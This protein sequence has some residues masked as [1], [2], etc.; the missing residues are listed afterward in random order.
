MDDQKIIAL[1]VEGIEPEEVM[2]W[3]RLNFSQYNHLLRVV[4][5]ELTGKSADSIQEMSQRGEKWAVLITNNQ[6]V[7]EEIRDL[8]EFEKLSY[9]GSVINTG[10]QISVT[11]IL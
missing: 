1:F 8:G 2:T 7:L 9:E 6:S 3:F 11:P 10:E 5:Y 4:K